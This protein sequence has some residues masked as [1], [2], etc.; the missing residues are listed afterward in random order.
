[1]LLRIKSWLLLG[2]MVYHS[3]VPVPTPERDALGSARIAPQGEMLQ[4]DP[5][6][7]AWVEGSHQVN[8]EPLEQVPACG[9]DQGMLLRLICPQLLLACLASFHEVLYFGP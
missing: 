5:G 3:C 1:M 6:D 9:G 7:P 2:V 8:V 4:L